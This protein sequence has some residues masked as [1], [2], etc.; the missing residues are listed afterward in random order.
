[1]KGLLVRTHAR[2]IAAAVT[3]LVATI[4]LSALVKVHPGPLPGDISLTLAWQHLILPHPWLVA[5]LKF[6]STINW[7][8]PAAI[9]A[10]AITVAFALW[11]RWLDILVS[12]GTLLLGSSANYLISHLVQRPRPSGHTIFI[13][14][15]IT[16]FYSFPSG[17]V[18]HT[19]TFFGIVLF[20]IWQTCRPAHWLWPVRIAL[21][22]QII[23]MPLSRILLG[24][25]WPSDVLAGV[26]DGSFWLLV[27][28]QVYWW[29]AQRWPTLVPSNE[30]VVPAQRQ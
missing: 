19:I 7:P 21:V 18:Q 9:T 1:M 4:V 20:L 23:L 15:Q 29:A 13:D 6:V 28:I 3:L 11:R 22:L 5:S 16:D 26:L 14:Q 17:H 30:Q 2:L 12:L 25:H 8:R 27:G 10:T 24:E